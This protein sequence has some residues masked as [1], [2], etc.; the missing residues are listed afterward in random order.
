MDSTDAVVGFTK[1]MTYKG[2]HP[3]VTLVNQVYETGKKLEKKVM[4]IYETA[5]E[6]MDG[7]GKWFVSIIPSKC[8]ETLGVELLV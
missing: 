8:K 1:S 4:D 2:Q 5:L 3:N 7:I 6:R